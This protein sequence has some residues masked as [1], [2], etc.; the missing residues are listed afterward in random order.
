[1]TRAFGK[2][3]APRVPGDDPRTT[4][5]DRE[6]GV[7]PRVQGFPSPVPGGKT[8]LVN[9]PSVRRTPVPPESPPEIKPLDAHGVL[10]GTHTSRERAEL[11]RGPNTTHDRTPPTSHRRHQAET[12]AHRPVPVPVYIVESGVKE[13]SIRTAAPRHVTL[14]ASTGDPV[15]IAGRDES[16]V[17]LLILNESTSSD[18][19]FGIGPADSVNDGALLPWPSNSYLTL[20]T[21]DTVWAI[22]ADSGTPKIS[23]I[24]E[25]EQRW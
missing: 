22:S 21:Q 4:M 12:E 24:S 7:S 17:R 6:A 25:H 14:N 5:E 3:N 15:Q 8:H 2:K 10:P 9:A 20:H 1:M 19:R 18:I 11:E 23:I 13:R 16:R